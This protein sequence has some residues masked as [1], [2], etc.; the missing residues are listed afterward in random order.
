MADQYNSA[1]TGAEIDQAVS[2]VQ[3]NKDAWS[4]KPQPSATT[5][6]A[7]G[8]ASAGSE[9]AYARGDHVHPDNDAVHKT[10]DESISG[11]KTFEAPENIR[12]IEQTTTKFTTSNGGAVIIGKEGSNSGTMLRFD[13]VDGTTRL[14]FR[15]S[16]APG[17]MVWEQPE[18]GAVLYIDL[19]APGVDHRRITF[20]KSGWGTLA[21]QSSVDDKVPKSRKINGY[22]LSENITLTASDVGALPEDALPAVTTADNGKFLRVVNGT[23][24]AVEI[25]NAN[26]GSF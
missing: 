17:A 14:R 3:N 7:P 8:T 1:H 21:Y 4:S 16:A 12:D 18:E 19:G 24:A 23:W 25:A 9:S 26:G 11:V 10:G 6:K 15:A 20:P 2:D 13:Q 5:P 22:A